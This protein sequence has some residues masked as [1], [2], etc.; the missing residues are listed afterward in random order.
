MAFK[1]DLLF[2]Y[3]DFCTYYADLHIPILLKYAFNSFLRMAT[4]DVELLSVTFN[5]NF[6]LPH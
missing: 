4:F 2:Y 1:W 6:P 5:R 3:F